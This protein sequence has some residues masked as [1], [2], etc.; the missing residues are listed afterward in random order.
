MGARTLNL[1]DSVFLYTGIVN[2]TN[3]EYNRE[4]DTYHDLIRRL[5]QEIILNAF[6]RKIIQV[7]QDGV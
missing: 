3:N 7:T 6:I 2:N 1:G 4:N 5:I